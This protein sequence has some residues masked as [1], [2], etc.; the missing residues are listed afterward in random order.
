[1]QKKFWRTSNKSDDNGQALAEAGRAQALE[2]VVSLFAGRETPI[3]P[4]VKIAECHRILVVATGDKPLEPEL[5]AVGALAEVVCSPDAQA[6]E[7][8]ASLIS[9]ATECE[10]YDL[11]ARAIIADRLARL[12]PQVAKRWS[13]LAERLY[14]LVP[15]YYQTVH[16]Y[17]SG[18]NR[19]IASLIEFF[20]CKEDFRG[21]F[22]EASSLTAGAS[23]IAA[24]YG[25]YRYVDAVTKIGD[26]VLSENAGA[27]GKDAVGLGAVANN[28]KNL[29]I[30]LARDHPAAGLYHY[31]KALRCSEV[32]LAAVQAEA[33]GPAGTLAAGMIAQTTVHS[34]LQ[35]MVAAGGAHPDLSEYEDHAGQFHLECS[36]AAARFGESAKECAQRI[37]AESG[38]EGRSRMAAE[39][40][41]KWYD[42]LVEDLDR[43]ISTAGFDWSVCKLVLALGAIASGRLGGMIGPLVQ[44]WVVSP[45]TPQDAK[46]WTPLRARQYMSIG[47]ESQANRTSAAGRVAGLARLADSVRQSAP[48]ISFLEMIGTRNSALLTHLIESRP[49]FQECSG[50]TLSHEGDLDALTRAGRVIFSEAIRRC[51]FEH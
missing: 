22:V 17:L 24:K 43:G 2:A 48:D 21:T 3:D 19:I 23:H 20:G 37:E 33:T 1:M 45:E 46:P 31:E 40:L 5:E 26:R 12:N 14:A 9:S 32:A 49:L 27:R 34:Q 28:L 29:H 41:D 11:V 7:S 30:T 13:T 47:G 25:I 8:I 39:I 6:A 42:E 38:M 15:K 4:W 36:L 16:N 44:L 35:Q 51:E 10:L 18:S 50:P